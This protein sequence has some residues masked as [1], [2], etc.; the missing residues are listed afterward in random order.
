[1]KTKTKRNERTERA[2]SALFMKSM[3]EHLEK[4][5]SKSSFEEYV[6]SKCLFMPEPVKFFSFLCT[7]ENVYAQYTHTLMIECERVTE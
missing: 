4:I 3:N 2:T 6:R 7:L 1:M 5:V